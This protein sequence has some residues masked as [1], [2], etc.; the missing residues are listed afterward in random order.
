VAEGRVRE[1]EK[2]EREKRERVPYHWEELEKVD[3]P[4]PVLSR[5]RHN[6]LDERHVDNLCRCSFAEPSWE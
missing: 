3:N 5:R 1:Q 6:V 4:F 2:R